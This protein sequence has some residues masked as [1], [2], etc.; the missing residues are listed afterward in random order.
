MG[1]LRRRVRSFAQLSSPLNPSSSKSHC[2]ASRRSTSRRS[3]VNG[4]VAAL[5]RPAVVVI[6]GT[7]TQ[8]VAASSVRLSSRGLVDLF[9]C[10][11]SG[12]KKPPMICQHHRALVVCSPDEA[13]RSKG[14]AHA[15]KLAPTKALVCRYQRALKGE[16]IPRHN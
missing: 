7:A 10:G 5:T 2:C 11:R 13:P 4:A 8:Q 3:V 16:V 12:G 9:S 1:D 15:H 14:E 6:P